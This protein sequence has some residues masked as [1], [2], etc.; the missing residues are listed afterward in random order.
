MD[1]SLPIPSSSQNH[2]N[3][4]STRESAS[5]SPSL[6]AQLGAASLHVC[7]PPNFPQPVQ[8]SFSPPASRNVSNTTIVNPFTSPSIAQLL[9]PP[10]PPQSSVAGTSVSANVAGPSS[11]ASAAVSSSNAGSPAKASGSRSPGTA[12]MALPSASLNPNAPFSPPET[13]T[14]SRAPVRRESPGTKSARSTPGRSL[15]T[16]Q[17]DVLSREVAEASRND[18]ELSLPPAMLSSA[19]KPVSAFTFSRRPH[20]NHPTLPLH[21]AAIVPSSKRTRSTSPLALANPSVRVQCSRR[22][23]APLNLSHPV[24]DRESMLPNHHQAQRSCPPEILVPTRYVQ[25]HPL[26]SCQKAMMLQTTTSRKQTS[27]QHPM[28]AHPSHNSLD[29]CSLPR[30]APASS[31]ANHLVAE[32]VAAD[33]NSRCLLDPSS[34]EPLDSRPIPITRPRSTQKSPSSPIKVPLSPSQPV[35]GRRDTSGDAE[36]AT[37][38]STASNLQRHSSVPETEWAGVGW[39]GKLAMTRRRSLDE[40][41]QSSSDYED[42]GEDQLDHSFEMVETGDEMSYNDDTDAYVDM[43]SSEDEAGR[44]DYDH[45]AADEDDLQMSGSEW[46]AGT[47]SALPPKMSAGVRLDADS[48]ARRPRLTSRSRTTSSNELPAVVQLQPYHNQVGGHNSI[49]QF[50]KRAVCKPLVGR[51]N[52]FYEAVEKEHPVLL[53]F[54]PQYLGVLNVTYRHVDA[55]QNES[56]A[57]PQPSM[58]L[59]TQRS[60]SRYPGVTAKEAE[61]KSLK[62]LARNKTT[63]PRRTMIVRNDRELT[64]KAAA[65]SGARSSKDRRI[66]ERRFRRSRWI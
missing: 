65:V 46:E 2:S 11:S 25:R 56:E 13:Y 38:D 8:T 34:L 54:I 49:F 16:Y 4:H 29:G 55:A 61:R 50:S 45:D 47:T 39:P 1:R 64:R 60:P 35:A 63:V 18:L 14:F 58:T 23:S 24:A 33:I 57:T 26:C 43:T 27:P 12:A 62:A 7:L 21:P 41:A 20:P 28:P 9:S 37:A 66:G 6:Q 19:V 59:R 15:T 30:R 32:N 3:V 51:E 5:L 44:P 53:A 36:D 42:D 40:R 31:L 48:A 52:E 17:D 22:L 10:F